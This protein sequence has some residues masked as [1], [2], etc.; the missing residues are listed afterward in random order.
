MSAPQYVYITSNKYRGRFYHGST[1]DVFARMV[2]HRTGKGSKHV[3]KYKLYNLVWYI[4][5]ESID[6]AIWLEQKL[7]HWR[8]TWKFELIED[9]NPN[10]N[11]LY[12][13]FSSGEIPILKQ[14]DIFLKRL[15]G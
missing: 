8:R 2:E 9:V 11:N 3:Q 12:E 7:K 13:T 1:Y 10:W 5:V 15:F 4:E 6:E 14:S